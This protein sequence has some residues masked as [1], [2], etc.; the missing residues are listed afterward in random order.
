VGEGNYGRL[1]ADQQRRYTSANRRLQ[2]PDLGRRKLEV[3]PQLPSYEQRI[4]GRN[5][6]L[7]D[8]AVDVVAS[9]LSGSYR[10]VVDANVK[11]DK[12]TLG[13]TLPLGARVKRVWLDGRAVAGEERETNRGLEMVAG[14]KGHAGGRHALVVETR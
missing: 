8:G 13:A 6:K 11:L 7:G 2:R 1:G 10:T 14:V 5:I 4:A 12:L 9:R 3:T